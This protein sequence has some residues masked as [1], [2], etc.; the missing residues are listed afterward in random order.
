MAE[1]LF[2]LLELSHLQPEGRLG[3]TALHRT[4]LGQVVQPTLELG[5]VGGAEAGTGHQQRFVG[6]QHGHHL[7]KRR[8]VRSQVADLRLVRDLL[9]AEADVGQARLGQPASPFLLGRQRHPLLGHDLQAH[10]PGGQRWADA[11]QKETDRQ[12]REEQAV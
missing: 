12:G 10:L 3:R 5:H 4:V 9:R 1:I 6:S 11:G 2:R 7:V 8:G